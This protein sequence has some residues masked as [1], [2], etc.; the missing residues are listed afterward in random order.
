MIVIND[1]FMNHKCWVVIR[2]KELL[3]NFVNRCEKEKMNFVDKGELLE[4]N[5]FPIYI[6]NSRNGICFSKDNVNRFVEYQP[7]FMNE[8]ASMLGVE[9]YERFKITYR[10]GEQYSKIAYYFSDYGIEQN[11][12]ASIDSDKRQELNELMHGLLVGNYTIMKLKWKPYRGMVY[13]YLTTGED[14]YTIKSKTWDDDIDDYSLFLSNNYF[15]T[16]NDADN[17]VNHFIK[18]FSDKFYE[19]EF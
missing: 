2:S 14:T 11:N 16:M 8:F 6:F 17:G 4:C 3:F 7:N 1:E 19:G 10:S 13:Y 9:L 12:N 5:D 15:K 18:V